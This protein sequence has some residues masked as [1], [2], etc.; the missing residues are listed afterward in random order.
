[1]KFVST[2]WLDTQA[3]TIERKA[4]NKLGHSIT[5]TGVAHH[6]TVGAIIDCREGGCMINEEKYAANKA[7]Y[8]KSIGL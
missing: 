1:M 6:L 2:Q 3:K 5:W 8:M 4:L 7:A